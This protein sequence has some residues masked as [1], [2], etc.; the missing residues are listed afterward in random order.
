MQGFS[1]SFPSIEENR[2]RPEIRPPRDTAAGEGRSIA[3]TETGRSLDQR[4]HGAGMGRKTVRKP[5]RLPI[6]LSVQKIRRVRFRA[7]SDLGVRRIEIGSFRVL[8]GSIPDRFPKT[9]GRHAEGHCPLHGRQ[10]RPEG[11]RASET[12]AMSHPEED[13][14]SRSHFDRPRKNL[15]QIFDRWL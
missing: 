3:R 6:S 14:L 12:D 8:P 4:D 11:R 5:E 1:K 15:R 13:G 7:R 10:P 9:R 2:R